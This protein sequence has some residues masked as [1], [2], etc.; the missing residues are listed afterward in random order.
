[1]GDKKDMIKP[2]CNLCG[3]ELNEFGGILL[4]PPDKQNKVNK[5]HICINCYKELERRL[6]Y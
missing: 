4:S 1:M 5:Y 6:K 3:K 2:M